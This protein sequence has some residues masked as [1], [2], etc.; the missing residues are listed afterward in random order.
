MHC[1][2]NFD[3]FQGSS[4]SRFGGSGK[5]CNFLKISKWQHKLVWNYKQG[6][7]VS[8]FLNNVAKT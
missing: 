1:Q 5:D 4:E 8:D 7:C 3:K 6:K 2:G